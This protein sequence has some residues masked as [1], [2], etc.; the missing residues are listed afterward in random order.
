MAA[1]ES[2][3]AETWGEVVA[4]G[5]G[6]GVFGVVD[7]EGAGWSAGTAVSGLRG[8]RR[9]KA[10]DTSCCCSKELLLSDNKMIAVAAF[11]ARV[12][13]DK[14]FISSCPVCSPCAVLCCRRR[15]RSR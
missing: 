13:A 14:A 15:R 5:S 7:E 4:A 11:H 8:R 1:S 9:R 6:A 2:A 3:S 12:R 10:G